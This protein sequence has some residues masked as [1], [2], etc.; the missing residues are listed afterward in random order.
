MYRVTQFYIHIYASCFCLRACHAI[1]SGCFS[2]G[3]RF[4][5]VYR[6]TLKYTRVYV[7]LDYDLRC[8]STRPVN[9]RTNL[10]AAQF[11]LIGWGFLILYILF[12]PYQNVHKTFY[13]FFLDSKLL[14][15]SYID[16]IY[17]SSY[18]KSKN[19]L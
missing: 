3:S 4:Y 12:T 11:R 10:R 13:S 14:L 6:F 5:R 8:G 17:K 15:H 19:I 18:L 7:V 1:F 16:Y 2:Y 9:R